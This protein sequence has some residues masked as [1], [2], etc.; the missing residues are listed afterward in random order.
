M[1]QFAE[2]S[3]ESRITLVE[4][5]VVLAADGFDSSVITADFL[6]H[7]GIVSGNLETVQP[8]VSTPIF[9][10][11]SFDGG[12]E[13]NATPDRLAFIHRLEGHVKLSKIGASVEI[14]TRFLEKVPFPRYQAIGI[15]PAGFCALNGNAASRVI[16]SLIENGTWMA[17]DNVN[18]VVSL[19]S[20]YS[21][22]DRQ[23]TMFVQDYIASES[24]GSKNPALM[25]NANIHREIGEGDHMQR[26]PS[27]MSILSGWKRDLQDFLKLAERFNSKGYFE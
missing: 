24:G 5:S 27:L 8:P 3:L 19:K 6:R 7:S 1:N 25:F 17:F 15:N 11:V 18:P 21:Y 13:I 16:N 4:L 12:L 9:A 14:V 22:Q 26:I 10:Q 20:V 2:N 23:I